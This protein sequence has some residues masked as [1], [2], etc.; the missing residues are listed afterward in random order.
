MFTCLAAD[1]L[2]LPKP[3][4]AMTCAAIAEKFGVV[5]DLG[6]LRSLAAT[7]RRGD[8]SFCGRARGE[9]CS[10]RGDGV[11]GA[12]AGVCFAGVFFFCC[13]FL[14]FFFFLVAEG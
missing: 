1:F 9:D 2:V 8:I 11:F 10:E 14:F 13:V 12:W 6:G 4:C 3:S 7:S 5:G